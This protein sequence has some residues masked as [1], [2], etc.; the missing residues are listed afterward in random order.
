MW[1]T[2]ASKGVQWVKHCGLARFY[3][4]WLW[5]KVCL[6]RVLFWGGRSGQGVAWIALVMNGA[7]D[8]MGRIPDSFML[9]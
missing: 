5:C 2:A 7:W 8:S 6:G 3:L 4:G 9:I 1:L